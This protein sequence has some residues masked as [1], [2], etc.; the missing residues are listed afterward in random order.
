MNACTASSSSEERV[1]DGAVSYGVGAP[2]TSRRPRPRRAGRGGGRAGGTPT[3]RRSAPARPFPK[4]LPFRAGPGPGRRA[5]AAPPAGRGAGS[6]HRPC[7][8]GGR[9]AHGLQGPDAG[10]AKRQPS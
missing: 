8:P 7:E 9:R 4:F 2:K 3:L 5:A 1:T 10:D 6:S